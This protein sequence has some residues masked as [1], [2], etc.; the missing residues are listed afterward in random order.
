MKSKIIP[1]DKEVLQLSESFIVASSRGMAALRSAEKQLMASQGHTLLH[2]FQYSTR[3]NLHPITD[4]VYKAEA[5]THI[6]PLQGQVQVMFSRIIYFMINTK[7]NSS[8]L[9]STKSWHLVLNNSQIQDTLLVFCIGQGDVPSWQA[10]CQLTDLS[11]CFLLFSLL[12]SGESN[13]KYNQQAMH[14]CCECIY[15]RLCNVVW[16]P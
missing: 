9:F 2:I 8:F 1:E 16:L 12:L 11:A 3:E 14:Q 4:L 7:E 5:F 15:I 6:P 10:S 13:N